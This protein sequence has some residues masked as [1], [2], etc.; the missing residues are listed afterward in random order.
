MCDFLLHGSAVFS[1]G[2]SVSSAG[3]TADLL[4]DLHQFT[5]QLLV[6]AELGASCSALRT[7]AQYGPRLRD[8]LATAFAFECVHRYRSHRQQRQFALGQPEDIGDFAFRAVHET[9]FKARAL[10]AAFYGR[11]RVRPIGRAVPPVT[12]RPDVRAALSGRVRR[13]HHRGPAH[14]RMDMTGPPFP[15]HATSCVYRGIGTTNEAANYTASQGL[16]P[17]RGIGRFQS[18]SS[19]NT[20]LGPITNGKSRML[21]QADTESASSKQ[22]ARQCHERPDGIR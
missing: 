6:V 9:A 15:I 5:T 18:G 2:V 7:A 1:S 10:T 4:T 13:H 17:R 11:A 21:P 14:G 20:K 3:V 12:P 19:A 22:R 8:C 16:L